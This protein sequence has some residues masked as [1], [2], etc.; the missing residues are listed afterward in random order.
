MNLALDTRTVLPEPI[1]IGVDFARADSITAITFSFI[2]CDC[3][4]TEQRPSIKVPEGWD[5]IEMD[6]SGQEFL[7]CP[8]CLEA[9][10]QKHF[11]SAPDRV[12]PTAED[13]IQPGKTSAFQI[14]LERQNDG[15]YQI[16]MHPAAA[17]MR[18]LPLGFFL[19]PASA[20]ATAAELTRYA[21]LAENKGKLP[22]SMGAGA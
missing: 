5:V 20:R 19:D 3:G 18:W 13:F 21:E 6:C 22:A 1:V 7:R 12:R 16:A 11:E 9:I 8:D 2:C 4:K 10:E 17:L 14:F 15:S